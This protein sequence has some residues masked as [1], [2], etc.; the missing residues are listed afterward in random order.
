MPFT[1]FHFG[2]AI[3]FKAVAPR[4]VSLTAFAGSQVAIDLESGY[5]LLRG[6]WPVHRLAHTLPLAT[7]IGIAA[8]ALVW[9]AG[10]WLQPSDNVGVQAEVLPLPAL[11]GGLLGGLSYPLLDAILHA[12]VQP[13]WPL[14]RVNPLLDALDLPL[15]H[16]MCCA[17]GAAGIALLL[18]RARPKASRK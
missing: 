14:T 6:E 18:L 15:L 7:A 8:G 10:R 3:L 9:T 13:F 5:H 4:H 2:P 11:I 1:P 12:D 16:Q 17:T